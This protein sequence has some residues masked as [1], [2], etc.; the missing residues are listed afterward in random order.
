[1]RLADLS[2]AEAVER[3]EAWFATAGD[4]VN[5]LAERFPDIAL[6]PSDS[7]IRGLLAAATPGFRFGERTDPDNVPLWFEDDHYL[8][9]QRLDDDSLWLVDALALHLGTFIIGFDPIVL[10]WGVCRSPHCPAQWANHP[11]VIGYRWPY[12][13]FEDMAMF[14][15]KAAAGQPEDPQHVVA[16]IACFLSVFRP[17]LAAS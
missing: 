14:A 16:A 11:A 12:S 13:T 17:R 10:H 5:W 8:E 1:M 3:A 15:V 9:Y 4:R 7:S 6:Y 2:E